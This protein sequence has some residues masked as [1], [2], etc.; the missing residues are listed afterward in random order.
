MPLRAVIYAR[1]SPTPKGD[2]F[3]G[4]N[5]E[6]QA[7]MCRAKCEENGWDVVAVIEDR[8][9]SA[10]SRKARPGW[11]RLLKMVEE[12]KV[13][14]IIGRHY[15]RLYRR[16]VD[17]EEL[18]RLTED[19]GVR[20]VAAEGDSL[21][22]DLTSATGLLQARVL[23]AFAAGETD[24]KRERQRAGQR[25]RVEAGLP[26][27]GNR[28]F[29]YEVDLSIREDE[30]EHIRS[31]YQAVL[32]GVSIATLVREWNWRGLET[33]KGH[34]WTRTTLRR[35]LCHPRNAGI[36]VYDG[37]EVDVKAAW[38]PLVDVDVYRAVE[39]LLRF[40]A[41]GTVADAF[42]RYGLLTGIATCA[43]R[44][45]DGL[46][47]GGPLALGTNRTRADGTQLRKYLCTTC[48]RASFPADM[49]EDYVMAGLFHRTSH[50]GA[51]EHQSKRSAQDAEVNAARI[52]V[53]DLR[54]RKDDLRALF[55]S[56]DVTSADF[57]SGNHLIDQ[58]MIEARTQL[59]IAQL[60]RPTDD[61]SRSR[62]P[63][64]ADILDMYCDSKRH[65]ELRSIIRDQMVFLAITPGSSLNRYR[66]MEEIVATWRGDDDIPASNLI[67]TDS[68]VWVGA[69][70]QMVAARAIWEEQRMQRKADLLSG[71][72]NSLAELKRETDYRHPSRARGAKTTVTGARDLG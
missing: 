21:G 29:G 8:D 37:L 66:S 34:A 20:I 52:V 57:I 72:M 4:G 49:L 65:E 47:C 5:L 17:L 27:W 25:R 36:V 18:I 16:P 38:E 48:H 40:G 41:R 28:P 6:Q 67:P 32:E 62:P 61:P 68:K 7:A 43:V 63:S 13:E 3:K 35:L 30:A 45:P 23:V 22:I 33:V 31:A 42:V 60:R 1:L 70:L 54:K 58:K 24:I 59:A 15:D 46:L 39:L 44:Q 2:A 64:F 19:T 71:Q 12:R 14:V 11:Q 53:K 10:V 26:W 51:L 9:V 69:H 50:H 56:G 55:V